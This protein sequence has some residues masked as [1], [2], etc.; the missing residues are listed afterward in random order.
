MLDADVWGVPHTRTP[1]VKW[2]PNTSVEVAGQQGDSRRATVDAEIDRLKA[3]IMD[4]TKAYILSK[5][6]D[7]DELRKAQ[8]KLV[9]EGAMIMGRDIARRTEH[10]K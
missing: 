9:D 1:S 10:A 6:L 8:R 2:K 4:Y 7:G 5:N 3:I